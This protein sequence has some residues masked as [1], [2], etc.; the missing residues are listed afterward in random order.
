MAMF[1]FECFHDQQDSQWSEKA[2][3]KYPTKQQQNGQ[4]VFLL[5]L[6][7]SFFRR[8]RELNAA[9]T[10]RAGLRMKQQHFLLSSA[11]AHRFFTASQG[12]HSHSL[13]HYSFQFVTPFSLLYYACALRDHIATTQIVTQN[14]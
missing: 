12:A 14:H 10:S 6:L 8:S 5:L 13:K 9:S 7:L 11:Q 4:I 3:R 2:S 1:F